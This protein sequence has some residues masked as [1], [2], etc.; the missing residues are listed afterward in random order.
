MMYASHYT[1]ML[2]LN[3]PTD[4]RRF[5]IGARSCKTKP[6]QDSKYYG[7]SVSLKKWIKEH[8]TDNI[9]K[10]ILAPWRT[11]EETLEHE[12]LLHQWFNVDKNPEYWNKARQT[13]SKFFYDFS[14]MK[15]GNLS[16]EHK[17]SISKT[18]TGVKNGNHKPETIVK[19][20]GVEYYCPETLVTKRFKVH[21]GE[22]PPEGWKKG[23]VIMNKRC[24]ITDGVSSVLTY[25]LQPIPV[26]WTKG[27]SSRR[28]EKGQFK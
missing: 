21:L 15:R 1:Y 17:Q 5:Y 8:G 12:K 7:S 26:G 13:S 24:W 14:G 4:E 16:D 18:K 25:E 3:K 2:V 22:H 10:V 20:M 28:N 27:R 23:R 9:E 11:R 6:E 19:Q